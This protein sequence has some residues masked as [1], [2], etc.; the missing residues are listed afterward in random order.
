MLP[1]EVVTR[2]DAEVALRALE[3]ELDREKRSMPRN[4]ARS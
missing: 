2:A 4:P 1:P 3:E